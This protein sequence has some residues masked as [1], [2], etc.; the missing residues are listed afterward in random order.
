MFS[1]ERVAVAVQ[2]GH[3]SYLQFQFSKR[4][5]WSKDV[6]T[7]VVKIIKRKLTC[8]FYVSFHGKSQFIVNHCVDTAKTISRLS[9]LFFFYYLLL[10]PPNNSRSLLRCKHF[11]YQELAAETYHVQLLYLHWPSEFPLIFYFWRM[12]NFELLS[13]L[14]VI[15]ANYPRP[16]LSRLE[17][18]KRFISWRHLPT[19]YRCE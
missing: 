9:L 4:H 11:K 8:S 12:I 18:N 14:K 1:A 7:A 15:S 5:F 17:W 10:H 2:K 13:S 19:R 16:R 3:E 6:E